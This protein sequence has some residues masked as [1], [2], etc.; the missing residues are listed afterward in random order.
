M[1]GKHVPFLFVARFLEKLDL[2]EAR[3]YG[4][5]VSRQVF[6]C[7]FLYD[8]L[9]DLLCDTGSPWASPMAPPQTLL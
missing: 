5:I 2:V 6:Q 9:Y 3:E 7:N 1:I 4:V 8:F